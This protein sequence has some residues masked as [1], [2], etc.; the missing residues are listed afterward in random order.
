MSGTPESPVP[1]SPSSPSDEA[2]SRRRKLMRAAISGAPLML[3]LPT[4]VSAQTVASAYRA[5][6]NDMQQSPVRVTTGTD[7]WVRVPAVS[8]TPPGNSSLPALYRIGTSYYLQSTGQA[9]TGS[10]NEQPYTATNVYLLVLFNVDIG[11]SISGGVPYPLT[12]S[13]N[14]LHRSAWLSVN[15]TGAQSYNGV[16]WVS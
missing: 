7:G 2:L 13:G 5:A 16:D 12:Q 15:P 8:L 10:V 6:Q 11:N 9:V 4:T 1:Q 3:S 14:G